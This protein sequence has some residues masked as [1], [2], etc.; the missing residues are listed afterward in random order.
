MRFCDR[1]NKI[2]H[3]F[4][5]DQKIIFHSR[6]IRKHQKGFEILFDLNT[7]KQFYDDI[8]NLIAVS[9]YTIISSSILKENYIKQYGRSQDVYGIALS[10]IMERTVFF[11]D[12]IKKKPN[13]SIHLEVIAEKRGK[14]ED[15]R[16]LRYYNELLDLGTYYITPQRIKGYFKH[17]HFKWKRENINGLQLADLIAYPIARYVLDPKMVNPS[18]ELLK[19]KFYRKG[20]RIYGLKIFP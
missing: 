16:L 14:K 11:L 20:K 9:N 3:N 19:E 2:N 13:Q 1:I 17:F 7:K 10:F 4:W 5:G 8:N 12:A 6:D 18:Y 15:K